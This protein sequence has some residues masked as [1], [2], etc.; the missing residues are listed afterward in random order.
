MLTTEKCGVAVGDQHLPLRRVLL[1][2]SAGDR[3]TVYLGVSCPYLEDANVGETDTDR[4]PIASRT[5][6]EQESNYPP[7]SA[8]LMMKSA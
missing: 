2:N 4:Y 8:L 1:S 3:G 6:T 7:D 5:G